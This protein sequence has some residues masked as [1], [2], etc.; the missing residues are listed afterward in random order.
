MDRRYDSWWGGRASA[1]AACGLL[2]AA[3]EGPIAD[4]ALPALQPDPFS[5]PWLQEQSPFPDPPPEAPAK[6]PGAAPAAATPLP[7]AGPARRAQHDIGLPALPEGMSVPRLPRPGPGNPEV[8]RTPPEGTGP[9]ARVGDDVVITRER[10]NDRVQRSLDAFHGLTG[11]VPLNVWRNVVGGTLL[12]LIERG[13]D[14]ARARELGVQADEAQVEREFQRFVEARGGPAMFPRFL[15]HMGVTEETVREDL[16]AKVLHQAVMERGI[17][18]I[19]VEA[20]EVEETFRVRRA[21]FAE[22]RR[23]HLRH[24]LVVLPEARDAANMGVALAKA[25]RVAK[26]VSAPGADF[27][28]VA[29]RHSEG[30]TATQGG[31]LGWLKRGQ[32][33]EAFDRVAFSMHCPGV[34][35]VIQTELGLHVI[36]CLEV[37]QGR[38][39]PL[40]DEL[41]ARIR[42]RLRDRERRK[43]RSDIN[44]TW[45]DEAPVVY[46]D[47]AIGEITAEV[48]AKSQRHRG[49]GT[50]PSVEELSP[51]LAPPT[52]GPAGTH[53]SAPRHP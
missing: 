39:L 40:D 37:R 16:R 32:M 30:A 3:C 46:L 29:R 2:L 27:A 34:S 10:Y 17:G 31:E 49:T 19:K 18:E 36:E 25:E 41:R 42:G 12:V 51:G 15:K 11:H 43:R 14:E 45:Y 13:I 53:G 23:R 1:V 44:R 6:A 4:D 8:A 28:A 48:R 22:P 47:A 24:V 5:A 7:D 9:V 26:L 21:E 52:E 50:G 35:G 38:W 33:P 20:S